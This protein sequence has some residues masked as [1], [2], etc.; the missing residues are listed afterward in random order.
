MILDS[1]AQIYRKAEGDPEADRSWLSVSEFH[2]VEG[3]GA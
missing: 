1:I 3:G 2:V